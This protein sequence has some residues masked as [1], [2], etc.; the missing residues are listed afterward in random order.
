MTVSLC[1]LVSVYS[2]DGKKV[3]ARDGA[4]KE[5]NLGGPWN[6]TE[7]FWESIIKVVW[8]IQGVRDEPSQA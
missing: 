8:A 7:A 4:A 2:Q 1:E 3:R 5:D 6:V